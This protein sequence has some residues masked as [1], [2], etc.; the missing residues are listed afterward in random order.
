MKKL[1]QNISL[2]Q[3]HLLSV[4]VQW[5]TFLRIMMTT[6]QT[7]K[8]KFWLCLMASLQTLWVTKNFKPQLK[9]CLLDAENW[10]L[11]ELNHSADI[12]YKDFVKIYRECT[13]KPYS[14]LTIDTTLPVSDPLRF[15]KNLLP[16]Y[17]N[18]SNW[19]A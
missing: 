17:K 18:D 7:K 13:K 6:T 11:Q 5:M 3:M 10:L 9:N 2:I 16:S 12:G 15:R 19:S 1:E 4:L 8:E 14:F